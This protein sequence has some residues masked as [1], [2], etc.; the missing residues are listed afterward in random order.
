MESAKS[1]ERCVEFTRKR[2]VNLDVENA[3]ENKGN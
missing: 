2:G 1:R 3:R